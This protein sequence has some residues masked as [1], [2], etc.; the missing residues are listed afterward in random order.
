MWHQEPDVSLRPPP[1]FLAVSRQ[2]HTNTFSRGDKVHGHAVDAI[3]QARWRRPVGK[4]MAKVAAAAAAMHLGPRHA[5]AFILGRLDCAFDRIVETRPARSAFEFFGGSKKP[6]PAS[7][8]DKSAWPLFTKERA[9]SR[10]LRPMPAHDAIL[11]R[12]KKVAPLFVGVSDFKLFGPHGSLSHGPINHTLKTTIHCARCNSSRHRM[13]RSFVPLILWVE[14]SICPKS[15]P[16]NLAASMKFTLGS[17]PLFI[18]R[19]GAEPSQTANAREGI[20][21]RRVTA[22]S[23]HCTR[24]FDTL[25][26][27]DLPV[28]DFRQVSLPYCLIKGIITNES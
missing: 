13:P 22:L 27:L 26:F 14:V 16:L 25:R 5:K 28:L 3:A 7:R 18:S 8:A 4:D 10:R 24:A 19:R 6:L 17:L 11:F 20:I 9:A 15:P 1:K 23:A 21:L 12:L 2:A